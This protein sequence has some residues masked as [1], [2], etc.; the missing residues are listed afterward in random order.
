MKEGVAKVIWNPIDTAA[1]VTEGLNGY[2][3]AHQT[4]QPKNSCGL[5]GVVKVLFAG[6]I[7]DWKGCGD[8][9]AAG[10]ILKKKL[11]GKNL[12]ISFVGKTGSFAD[13]LQRQYGCEEWFDLV[14]KVTREELQVRFR[15]ADVVVF[16]SWWE[17]MPMVCIEAM[18]QGAIVVGSKNGGMSEIIQDGKSGWLVEPRDPQ[19]IADAIVKALDMTIT[20]REQMSEQAKKRIVDNF[21]T[22]VIV[23]QTLDYFTYVI[24]DFKNKRKI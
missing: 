21:S 5:N 7:C 22:E 23:K 24:T 4:A 12:K 1:W 8:L 19:K 16:P 13:E 11:A 14:G 10:N 20:E 9:A 2:L 17:N 18:L 3:K 6:T 15:E